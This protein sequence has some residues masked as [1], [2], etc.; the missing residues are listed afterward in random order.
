M[1]MLNYHQELNMIRDGDDIG[2]GYEKH[3]E[4]REVGEE[5]VGSR[6]S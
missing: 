3:T 5:I 6:R 1:H 2:V 4:S